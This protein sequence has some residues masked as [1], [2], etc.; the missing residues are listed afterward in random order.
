LWENVRRFKQKGLKLT[1][2]AIIGGGIAARS[3]L[4]MMAKKNIRSKILIFYSDKFAFPCSLH[5]TA[6][7]APRGISTGHSPLGDELVQGFDRFQRHFQE[8]HPEGVITVP[9]INGA[10]TKIEAFTKRFPDGKETDGMYLAHEE[11]FLVRPKDYLDW[12]L[13]EAKKK[14][15]VEVVSDFVTEVHGEKIR[16]IDG[17][18][19]HAEKIFFT[20]GVQNELWCGKKTKSV[21]GS[22]L[23]F[24]DVS[25]EASF[26]LTLEGNNL[27]FD[28]ERK[29]LLIGSTTK[30]SAL[31]L[32]P[33]K[34][35]LQV[36]EFLK[37]RWSFPLPE[38]SQGIIRTG[39]R[40]KGP[41]REAYVVREGNHITI[42]GLYK[43]GY[44]LSLHLAEK[45]L[46]H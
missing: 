4:Y 28:Q 45:V 3:L 39:L 27:I 24:Q 20:T 10:L 38:F 34:T 36:Y 8:D 12:L 16:T 25:G 44:R 46:S 11:A 32:P 5:S 14:L 19:F 29:T 6:I 21:Q 13:K 23:E 1:T 2:I 37:E 40:E 17:K 9:Q 42:G 30:E 22:Y 26:S 35:L 41:K 15:D 18:E 7:V 43:N 33:E 31:Y